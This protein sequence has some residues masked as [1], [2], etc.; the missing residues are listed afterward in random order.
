[1][2]KETLEAQRIMQDLKSNSSGQQE[3][4]RPTGNECPQCGM[5]HPPLQPGEKCPN[6]ALAGQESLGG[7]K[8]EDINK[9]LVDLRNIV[10][11]TM[12]KKNIQNGRK[13]FQTA[14]IKLT[15]ELENYS[16]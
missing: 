16:E 14:I 2:D 11:S 9:F 6:V 7:L 12:Q 3:F 4:A 1:M 15:K 8:E 13:F 10:I 5:I